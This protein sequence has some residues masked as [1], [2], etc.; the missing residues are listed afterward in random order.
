[1]NTIKRVIIVLI[2]ALLA[3][4]CS[5]SAEPE[6]S[7]DNV[8]RV[9][10]ECNYAPF[11]WTITTENEFTQPISSVDFADGY[12]VV[13]ASRIAEALGMELQIVKTDWDNLIP[14][15]NHDQIDLIIAGM[16]ATEERAKEVNFTTP[17]Y[18]SEHVVIVRKD[19]EL[20]NITSI[21]E[22]SGYRVTGQ[23][24]TI[25]DE[26]IDQID[27]VTHMTPKEDYPS[28]VF[29]LQNGETDALTA[30]LPV[31]FGVCSA[32][33]DLIYI[34]FEEGNGFVADATVSI[35]LRKADEDLLSRVQAALDNISAEERQQ[36]M[37]DA[38]TRQP[39]VEE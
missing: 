20:A 28:M 35:A 10:M 8:L 29:S 14:S 1:M 7:D 39:A 32:N 37:L 6:T 31:A 18:E 2:I 16:T 36:I 19:S 38:V 21:Q 24:A 27:G 15:L 17:Y 22:L 5:Q 25:Y 4:G 11:N 9:G 30:E 34:T 12:D 13:I 33:P 3:A 23:L 26:I